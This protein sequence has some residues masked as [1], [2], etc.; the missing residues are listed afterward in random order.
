[1]K[2]QP[3]RAER[4]KFAPDLCN[5]KVVFSAARFCCEILDLCDAKRS[6]PLLK[7][8]QPMFSERTIF[9][10]DIMASLKH[11]MFDTCVGVH[12]TG[13]QTMTVAGQSAF[14]VLPID[15]QHWHA[16]EGAHGILGER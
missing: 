11:V 16:V 14:V 10:R 9:G 13:R 7:S 15:H 1:M 3:P 5:G 6:L 2:A 12:K 4:G 8:L